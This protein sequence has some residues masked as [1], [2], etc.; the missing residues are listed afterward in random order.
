MSEASKFRRKKRREQERML[1][2]HVFYKVRNFPEDNP[3]SKDYAFWHIP[4]VGED[5]MFVVFSD[6][7]PALRDMQEAVAEYDLF[8]LKEDL[9]SDFANVSGISEW[10]DSGVGEDGSPE[11]EWCDLE[12]D[13]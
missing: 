1:P 13:L 6:D 4:Q 9:R 2:S 11:W 8:L 10:C 7:L 12:D 3:A 5:G